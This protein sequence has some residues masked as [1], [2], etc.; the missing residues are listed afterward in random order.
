MNYEN[1]IKR[2][3]QEHDALKARMELLEKTTTTTAMNS[4]SKSPVDNTENER[5]RPADAD[6]RW[7]HD[8]SKKTCCIIMLILIVL[9]II[10]GPI[11]ASLYSD[12]RI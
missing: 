12:H 8:R 1:E 3:S 4:E 7:T 5:L 11:I 10:L 9:A 2:L 6:E